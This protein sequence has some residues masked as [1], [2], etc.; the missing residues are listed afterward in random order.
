MALIIGSQDQKKINSLLM[1]FHSTR[2][3][4]ASVYAGD[5]QSARIHQRAVE[6]LRSIGRRMAGLG[7]VFKKEAGFD[8]E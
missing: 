4:L 7:L 8:D 1:D 6:S 3:D 5:P 2:H